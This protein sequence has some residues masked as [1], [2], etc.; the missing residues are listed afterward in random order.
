MLAFAPIRS[1]VVGWTTTTLTTARS[2]S[3]S[4]LFSTRVK[5]QSQ[6]QSQSEITSSIKN[7]G[8][9][10]NNMKMIRLHTIPKEELETIVVSWGHPKYR[11]GQI[12][13]WVKEQGVDDIDAMNNIPKKLRAQLKEHAAIQSLELDTE[14]VSKD[15]TKKRVYRLHDGQLIESVLM[16]YQ[17]GRY[18]A[19]ISS[20]AGCAQGCVFCATGQMGFSRQLTAD[21]ILE[22]V[23]IFASELNKEENND[24]SKK[25]K[26]NGRRSMRIV[27]MGMGEPLANYRNVVEAVHRIQDE[28]G[29]GARKITISTV[30]LVPNIRKLMKDLPQVRLAVSLHC[31]TDEERTALLPANRRNGGLKELMTCLEEYIETTGRRITLEWALIQNENDTPETAHSLGTLIKKYN[32]RRDMIHIN[33]IPLNPT[34]GYG[35]GPS[36]RERVNAFC[37]ILESDYGVACTPRVRRGIDINAGCGQLKAEVEKRERGNKAESSKGDEELLSLKEPSLSDFVP[38]QATPV[39]AGVYEDE[40]SE[41]DEAEEQQGQGTANHSFLIDEQSYDFEDDEFED[42]VYSSRE[43]Q[44]EAARLINLV[45]GTV[46]TDQNQVIRSQADIVRYNKAEEESSSEEEA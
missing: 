17:D 26:T 27:F 36:A 8:Q 19:C 39:V 18:T 32:L 38:P 10:N 9:T 29:I 34:G 28:I 35:G 7:D 45:K 1:S 37:K 44:D 22:Q 13:K 41:D 46:V 11:A 40:D 2:R 12:L 4:S 31:A 42:Y 15:G 24:G 21:E 33:V 20:Q 43:E 23:S 14:L 5:A 3:R 6:V 16:P 25:S 30:G